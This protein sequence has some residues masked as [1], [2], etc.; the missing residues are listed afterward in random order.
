MYTETF[1]Y[2]PPFSEKEVA[3]QIK[4]IMDNGWIPGIE[5]TEDP[6]LENA[7]WFFWKLPLFDA[8]NAEEVMSEL[9]ACRE[10]NPKAYIKITGYDNIRQG[11]VLA[12]VAFKPAA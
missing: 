8:E 3:A 1:S 5:Y 12:F 6:G 4:Y 2:L 9:K 7:Y 11:Q 10:Q